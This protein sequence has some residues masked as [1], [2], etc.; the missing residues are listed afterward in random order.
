MHIGSDIKNKS[1]EGSR[2]GAE[3]VIREAV[4]KA[5]DDCIE[6]GILADFFKHNAAQAIEALTE[7][8]LQEQA[9]SDIEQE[10]YEEGLAEGRAEGVNISSRIMHDLIDGRTLEEISKRHTVPIEVITQIQTEISDA[11]QII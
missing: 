11:S 7:E 1:T 8:M 6:E 5:V 3:A 10:G 9:L 2:A 4:S